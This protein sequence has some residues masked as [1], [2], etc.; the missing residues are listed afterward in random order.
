MNPSLD[1]I[2]KRVK[3]LRIQHNVSMNELAEN[4]NIKI[5]QSTISNIESDKVSP[6][7][8]AIVALSQYF[9]VST[10]WLLTGKEWSDSIFHNSDDDIALA[11]IVEETEKLYNRMIRLKALTRVRKLHKAKMDMISDINDHQ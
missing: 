7:A 6:N 3:L 8:E 1:S 11:E 4:L 9:N 5:S 2:G 10:D